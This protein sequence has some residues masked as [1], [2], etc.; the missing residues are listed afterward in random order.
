MLECLRGGNCDLVV[1]SRHVPGGGLG[2]LSVGR[3]E[4][5]DTAARLSG[6]VY[7]AVLADPM[8]GFLMLRRELLEDTV[9][10]LSGQGF[11]I[12]LNILASPPRSVRI[13]EFPYAFRQRRHGESKLDTPM[14][15]GFMMLI[16]DNSIGHRVPVRFALFALIGGLGLMVHLAVPWTSLKVADTAFATTQT[17]AVVADDFEFLPQ[18]PIQ[19]SR[20]GG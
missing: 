7:R 3:G 1:G 15:W 9:R 14:A 10:Q 11:R 8:S 5:T 16:A 12:L 13:K 18:Q 20:T 19:L 6:L 4:I 17:A 2:D